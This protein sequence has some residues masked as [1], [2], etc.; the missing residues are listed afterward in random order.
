MVLVEY[1]PL[2]CC[3]FRVVASCMVLCYFLLYFSAFSIYCAF[4]NYAC[5]YLEYKV[6]AEAKK[7]FGA[8]GL[9]VGLGSVEV[10]VMKEFFTYTFFSL[11]SDFGGSLGLFVGFSFFSLWDLVKDCFLF[12]GQVI[13]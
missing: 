2:F 12:S 11:V 4:S 6:G 10:T 13:K 1:L 8:F 5:T 9:M 7:D 3:K